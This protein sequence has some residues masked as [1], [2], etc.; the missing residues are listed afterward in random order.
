MKIPIVGTY[1]MVIKDEGGNEKVNETVTVADSRQPYVFTPTEDGFYTVEAGPEGVKYMHMKLDR[2]KNPLTSNDKLLE[3]VQFG[4]VAWESMGD[5]FVECENMTF[6][7]GIDTPDLSKV[8]DMGAMFY[9]C[10]SFNQPLNEWN[11]SNVTYMGAMFKYCDFFNQPLD[12]WDVSNVKSM[13]EMFYGCHS[14]NQ[15]LNDWNVSKVNYMS[16]MFKG[17]HS[18]NQ[19]LGNWD[20]SNVESMNGMFMGCFSFN[21]PLNDWNVS[22][23][24]H[25]SWMFEG[26]SAFN[27]PLN[28]WNVSNVIDMGAMFYGCSAFNQP[29]NEWNVSNVKGMSQ[30]F[31]GCDSF[32]QPLNNWDV[33]NVNG[34]RD[35]F[36][37]CYSF[38]QPLGNWDVSKV[39]SMSGMFSGCSAF[40]QPLS[41]WNVSN[42]NNMGGMFSGCSAFNQPLSN[43]NVSKVTNMDGM[44]YD[45]S[46]FNQPLD[47]WDVSNVTNMRWMFSGCSAFNQP[48][49]NWNVSNVTSMKMMFLDCSSF[50]QPLNN[51][52]VNKVEDMWAMFKGCSSFNQPI[53]NWNVSKVT[54]MY[55][56]FKGCSSFNQPLDNWNVSNV[57]SMKRMFDGCRSFN[58]PLG[59]WKIR[60]VIDWLFKTAMSPSNYSQTLVGWAEQTDIAKDLD[61][62]EYGYVK[63]LIYNDQGRVARQKLIDKGWK[64]DGDIYQSRGVATTPHFFPLALNKECTLPLETWGVEDTEEVTLQTD[65]E[66]IISYELTADK[67]GV[68]IKGLGLGKCSLIATIPYKAGVDN[69]YTNTCEIEVY[70]PVERITISPA[71]KTLKVREEF[72]FTANIFP[73]YATNKNV[74]WKSSIDSEYGNIGDNWEVFFKKAGK[75]W[76]YAKIDEYGREFEG[77]C[78]VTVVDEIA[79]VTRILLPESQTLQV[80]TTTQLVA[81]V[82]PNHA[83]QGLIWSSS[84]PGI[85]MV[86]GGLIWGKKKGECTIT[87][88]SLDPTC[89]I[90]KE[91]KITVEGSSNEG[92][93]GEGDN[94]GSNPTTFSVTLTQSANGKIE[95]EGYTTEAPITVA[96][97]TELTV[98]ATPDEGYKLK[99]LTAGEEDITET[100]KFTVKAATTVTAVFEKETFVVTTNV[101]NEAWGSIELAGA[102]DLKAV[103]YGTELTVTITEKEGYKLKELKANEEDI[104]AIQKFTV[105]AAT[106]VTAIF[107]SKQGDNNE[108]GGA[109]EDALLAGIVVAPN[110]FSAQLRILNPEG[111]VAR[112]EVVNGAGVVVRSGALSE[113]EL[114]VD[115]E[116]LSAGIYFVR[117]ETQNGARKSVM[118]SK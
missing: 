20:V 48:L 52:D 116:A 32:N 112:Y 36:H 56:M 109:V 45:C 8:T 85:A 83:E 58:Q 114:V 50:N 7:A 38:N 22:K 108:P 24:R 14:F 6:A 75:W 86:S 18:F 107:A 94:N 95:I 53:G 70:I 88:K 39:I 104:T 68:H 77:R 41:N 12:N 37:G 44:F 35:M 10:Y 76:I 82:L 100:K 5:M 101:N 61:F 73:S 54:Y 29:L 81:V 55:E 72:K 118:V 33:S 2:D 25:M 17:C 62:G 99:T 57:N 28:N 26:C 111:V 80:G 3:V 78:E 113:K 84:D 93:N 79:P 96:K 51:W 40:N 90:T 65:R 21:Q 11:V 67:K 16:E 15:P 117:I 110:P 89:T 106:T 42:V 91:C 47:K 105:K 19:P 102:S 34:M 43:W 23:V 92:N 103:P 64:F 1:K 30:M 59:S 115:T 27:Q 71:S 66:G 9:G 13:G 60:T 87:V 46:A 49:D 69:S 4:T 98:T 97:D 31:D 74:S 63:G